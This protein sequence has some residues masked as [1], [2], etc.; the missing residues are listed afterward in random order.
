MIY[1]QRDSKAVSAWIR[2]CRGAYTH[3]GETVCAGFHLYRG[4]V[5]CPAWA[6]GKPCSYC[7][8]RTTFNSAR[9]PSLRNGV[10]WVDGWRDLEPHKQTVRHAR[11]AV[12][13]WLE[14]TRCGC[15]TWHRGLER[16]QRRNSTESHTWRSVRWCGRCRLSTSTEVPPPMLL[17]TSELGDGLGFP[18]HDN[19][20]VGTLLDAFSN[21]DTNPHG[22]KL[23]LLTKAGLEATKAHLE[24]RQPS[25]NV[26]LSWSVGNLD[27]EPFWENPF[28]ED[29]RLEAAGWTRTQGWR[30]RLRL[31]PLDDSDN[32]AIDL[33]PHD[34]G[35]EI[36]DDWLP[37]TAGPELI[38]L[39][40]L[41]HRGGRVKLPAEQ[42]A[43]IY[44]QAIE[45]LRD[46]GYT[47]QIGLCKETPEMVE[48]VLGVKPEAMVCNCLP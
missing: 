29:G 15:G 40:T 34:H 35:Q 13:K 31:D 16:V 46:G 7:F 41:R 22:H 43:S 44:E 25:E 21:P 20:H 18:P 19:P 11:A 5:G 12:E 27:A 6:A 14:R 24:G 30:V 28:A 17:N 47:G 39:G 9:D 48:S 32:H 36:A 3:G 42:R 33:P 8:L 45:G 4:F 1:R 23:L 26:I 10:A 37:R 2:D 38:T